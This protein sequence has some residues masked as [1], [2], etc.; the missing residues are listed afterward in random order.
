MYY[1]VE[2]IK[3]SPVSEAVQI[4]GQKIGILMLAG[5]MTLAFYND[6]QRLFS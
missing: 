4:A 6:F 3:G 2:M 1:L 5:L